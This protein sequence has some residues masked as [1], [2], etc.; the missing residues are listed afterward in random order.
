MSRR[1]RWRPWVWRGLLALG[2]IIYGS[3]FYALARWL[4]G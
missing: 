3:L 1:S 2:V 4:Q